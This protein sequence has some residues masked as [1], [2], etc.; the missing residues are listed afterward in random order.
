MK[1]TT[2][3]IIISA[4]AVIADTNPRYEKFSPEARELLIAHKSTPTPKSVLPSSPARLN[5]AYAVEK[6]RSAWEELYLDRVEGETIPGYIPFMLDHVIT[7]AIGSIGSTNS[8]PFLT[9]LYTQL[10]EKGND[11]NQER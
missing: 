5:Y 1:K 4:F 2:V 11:K 8:I 10:L 7:S 3:M 9:D 6:Y